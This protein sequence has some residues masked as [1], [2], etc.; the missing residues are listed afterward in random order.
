[1]SEKKT[2]KYS[3]KS[4]EMPVKTSGV[5]NEPRSR[6]ESTGEEQDRDNGGAD[7]QPT[8]T[9]QKNVNP[10]MDKV[11]KPLFKDDS[12]SGEAAKTSGQAD[13]VDG[14]DE[15]DAIGSSVKN[16]KLKDEEP[17]AQPQDEEQAFGCWL[18]D[19]PWDHPDL[20]N[21]DLSEKME[22]TVKISETYP[23]LKKFRKGATM[24]DLA[25]IYSNIPRFVEKM[26]PKTSQQG[27][28]ELMDYVKL[29]PKDKTDQRFKE[30]ASGSPHISEL[31]E[32]ASDNRRAGAP[33]ESLQAYSLPLEKKKPSDDKR[34]F[35][36]CE[37]VMEMC[38]PGNSAYWFRANQNK[39]IRSVNAD[40][41]D[42]R[43]IFIPS[44]RRAKIALL[45]W[46]KDEIITEENTIRIL[47]VRPTEFE[48]YVQYCG[49]LFPVICLPQDEI[50]VGYARF[51]IQKIASCLK[52]YFIWMLDDSIMSF[53]EY[54]PKKEQTGQKDTRYLKFGLVFERIERLVKHTVGEDNPIVAIS[55]RRLNPFGTG[56]PFVCKPPQCAVFL[57]IKE[58]SAKGVHYRPELSVFEDM[59]FGYECERCGLKVFRDNRIMLVDHNKWK[60]TGASSPSVTAH[61]Q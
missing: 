5:K 24:V 41:K 30:L 36:D 4:K 7:Q 9:P 43:W 25:K 28:E 29:D 19:H 51:W 49:H 31:L 53:Q 35:L 27:L 26:K 14:E 50:G 61:L 15:I 13:S 54:I 52:L 3:S 45:N 48:E 58:L 6:K 8:A 32:G 59:M 60:H 16:L 20:S 37:Y 42:K 57:N 38:L 34:Y 55:P 21:P 17:Q 23:A 39:H 44:F 10:G 11:R 56:E 22:D 18:P 33:Q 12:T 46:P 40:K 47:V 2:S 1:M